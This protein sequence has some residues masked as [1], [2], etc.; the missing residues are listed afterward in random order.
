MTFIVFRVPSL[1]FFIMNVENK[2]S[3]LFSHLSENYTYI[4]SIDY[5]ESEDWT[6]SIDSIDFINSIDSILVSHKRPPAFT[7]HTKRK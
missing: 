2:Q 6:D 1:T 5:I 7:P 4:D 3:Y